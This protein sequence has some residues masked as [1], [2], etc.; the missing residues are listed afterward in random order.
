MHFD[1]EHEFPAPRARVAARLTD[2]QFHLGLELPDLGRPQV[3]TDA[4]EGGQRVLRLRYEYV[5]RLDPIARK[6][7][8]GGTLT[9]V[10]ELRLD[11]STFAG[12]L[13]FS[14]DQ[15]ADRFNGEAGV[16]F[17]PLDG[18]AR[19]RRRIS[20]DLHIRIPLVGG[21]AERK[22]VPGVLRRLDV[23]A[24]ALAASVATPEGGATGH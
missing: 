21:T 8:G 4:T 7:V 15:Q 6:V 9:W 10:Q 22:I 13:R 19:C 16:D 2:A 11:L 3:V 12:T 5:G 20:G 23:E 24:E 18:D 17:T 14:A 1:T